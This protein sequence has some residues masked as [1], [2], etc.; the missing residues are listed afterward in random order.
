LKREANSFAILM[1]FKKESAIRKERMPAFFI[2]IRASRMV[3]FK[4]SSQICVYTMGCDPKCPL[5]RAAFC[6]RA[7]CNAVF[8]DGQI[9][10]ARSSSPFARQSCNLSE[11]PPYFC[12]GDLMLR[13]MGGQSKCTMHVKSQKQFVFVFLSFFSLGVERERETWPVIW[14]ILIKVK[15]LDID[16]LLV[17]LDDVIVLDDQFLTIF[18]FR[19]EQKVKILFDE[20]EN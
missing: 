3:V 9:P 17:T 15:Y 10:P 6:S 13:L 8:E 19:W 18:S 12:S 1:H 7:I 5:N 4:R 11:S 20:S 16:S 2:S 14:T